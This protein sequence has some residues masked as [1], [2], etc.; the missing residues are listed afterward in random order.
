M[1]KQENMFKDQ[2]NVPRGE[3]VDIFDPLALLNFMNMQM[4]DETKLFVLFGET[5]KIEMSGREAAIAQAA[6][7]FKVFA[8]P[9]GKSREDRAI[10]VVSGLSGIGKTRLMEEFETI[11]DMA[12]VGQP[13]F[14]VIVSYEVGHNPQPVE[15]SMRIEA[16]FSWRLL[17]R[18]FIE[19]NGVDFIKWFGTC[20]PVNGAG[21]TL[22]TALEVI[23]MKAESLGLI[24]ENDVFHMFLG[25]D[26]YHYIEDVKGI[27]VSHE[28]LL[29][30]LINAINGVVASPVDNIRIY[31]MGACKNLSVVS[32]LR[33]QSIR[34]PMS[35]LS[36]AEMERSIE[37]IPCGLNLLKQAAVRRH[38]FYLGGVPRWFTQYILTLVDKVSE[39]V[40]KVP[41]IEQAKK[42]FQ[43]TE[44]QYINEW[45]RVRENGRRRHLEQI[46]FIKLAAYSF[47]GLKVVLNSKDIG[48][49][50]WAHLEGSVCLINDN[51]I[52]IPYAIV[53][54]IAGYDSIDFTDR[55]VKCFI[56]CLKGLVETVDKLM[57]EKSPWQLW[58]VFGAYLHA[59][60]I[61]ALLII[62]KDTVKVRELFEGALING[63]DQEVKLRPMLVMETEDKLSSQLGSSVKRKGRVDEVHDYL[64]EGIVVINGENGQ[65]VDPFFALESTQGGY[66]LIN[67]QRK[68]DSGEQTVTNLIHK[69]LIKPNIQHVS[70]TVIPCLFSCFSSFSLTEIPKNSIV[71]SYPQSK[72]YH[73]SMWI[74]PAASPYINVNNTSITHLKNILNGADVATAARQIIANKRKYASIVELDEDLKRF[75]ACIKEEEK[76][77]I[78]FAK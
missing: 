70:V 4:I 34:L 73:G 56:E 78:V 77:R 68:H 71:V 23:R 19:G 9:V 8:N 40:D 75:G 46:E 21:L 54:R 66:I 52:S 7:K 29:Q 13:R 5:R 3:R 74:H 64:Q 32:I 65:G 44:A 51:C 38:L 37:S 6:E 47:S 58:G 24:G 48:N 31:P 22:D 1:S 33:T 10:P 20:L 53:R 60:R 27:P 76:E 2:I 36:V 67:D 39:S 30:D 43:C 50:S 63:C 17:Y 57:Y 72:A 15:Q 26:K 25:V 18:V 49:L 62:G 61:N 59:L 35:F 16:S 55:A 28:P 42:A 12:G 14:G 11:F 69:A 45:G 41:T